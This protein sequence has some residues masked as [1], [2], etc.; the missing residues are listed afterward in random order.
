M[1]SFS[2]LWPN[3]DQKAPQL[4]SKLVFFPAKLLGA[5]GLLAKIPELLLS[6]IVQPVT[7]P[8]LFERIRSS[9]GYLG[10]VYCLFSLQKQTYFQ[11]LL[12]PLDT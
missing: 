7:A 10:K 1:V 3:S 9:C 6:M 4:T 11:L 12:S 5:N 2:S 8:D